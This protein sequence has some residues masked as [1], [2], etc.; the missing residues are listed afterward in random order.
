LTYLK[1]SLGQVANHVENCT[2]I[3][4]KSMFHCLSVTTSFE[5]ATRNTVHCVSILVWDTH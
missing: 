2:I 5:F 4:I 3:L 1:K